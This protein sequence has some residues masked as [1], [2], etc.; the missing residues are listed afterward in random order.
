[1][2]DDEF[3]KKFTNRIE[4]MGKDG[5]V[6][7]LKNTREPINISKKFNFGIN[8]YKNSVQK[9][10]L[11]IN[12]NLPI[13]YKPNLIINNNS[14]LELEN[15]ISY[16]NKENNVYHKPFYNPFSDNYEHKKSLM[17]EDLYYLNNNNLYNSN[18]NQITKKYINVRNIINNKELE[19]KKYNNVL[20][21]SLKLNPSKIHT[22]ISNKIDNKID[23]GYTPY[24]L[25]SYKKLPQIK[26]GKLG[27]DLNNKEWKNKQLKMK[28]MVDYG[29]EVFDKEMNSVK[30]KK[31][32]INKKNKIKDEDEFKNDEGKWN[33]KIQ[34]NKSLSNRI[35][36]DSNKYFQEVSDEIIK[37]REKI[38]KEE[39]HKIYLRR[40]EKMK[41][42]FLK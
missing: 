22:I 25:K 24:N 9:N 3:L 23:Y 18:S 16:L 40:L 17:N 8:N 41:N 32:K 1:M 11:E 33:K 6:G 42:L 36:R 14:S 21:K 31:I 4:Q 28:K 10:Y 29:K 37:E 27:R 7:I 15:D 2:K 12:R 39:N 5:I 30:I 38:E 34:Y 35:F 26:L 20:S 13:L 19:N